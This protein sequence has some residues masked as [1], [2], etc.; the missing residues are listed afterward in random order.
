MRFLRDFEKC[1][2]EG[3]KNWWI[4]KDKN[5]LLYFINGFELWKAWGAGNNATRVN[6][7]GG[8]I[9]RN[10]YVKEDSRRQGL[11]TNLMDQI[12]MDFMLEDLC[13]FLFPCHFEFDKCPFENPKEAKVK[14]DYLQDRKGLYER[15]EEMGFRR[16]KTAY[17]D[18][19]RSYKTKII[20]TSISGEDRKAEKDEVF[21]ALYSPFN[22]GFQWLGLASASMIPE[23]IWIENS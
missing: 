13:L 20:N 10:I 19:D 9:L 17:Y 8:V 16:M 5:V 12:C 2:I 18:M 11:F 6:V 7:E 3:D 14:T 4:N 15:Y 23:E 21:A 22:M 1:T